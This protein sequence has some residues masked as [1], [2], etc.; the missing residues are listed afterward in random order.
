MSSS[1][2]SKQLSAQRVQLQE[3]SQISI[4]VNICDKQVL[5]SVLT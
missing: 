2:Q 1:K 3:F 5:Y 4:A